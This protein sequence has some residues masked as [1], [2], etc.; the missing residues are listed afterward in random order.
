[1]TVCEIVVPMEKSIPAKFYSFTATRFLT[2]DIQNC[3][4]SAFSAQVVF[5]ITYA[6]IELQSSFYAHFK[7]KKKFLSNDILH[8]YIQHS[9][10]SKVFKYVI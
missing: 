8:Q 4:K 2:A 1:M 9:Y 10:V 5:G 3:Q 6:L 7:A